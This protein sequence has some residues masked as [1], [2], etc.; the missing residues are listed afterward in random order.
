MSFFATWVIAQNIFSFLF[1]TVL[2]LTTLLPGC[3]KKNVLKLV[4]RLRI[5][6]GINLYEDGF[7]SQGSLAFHTLTLKIVKWW[8]CGTVRMDQLIFKQEKR[9]LNQALKYFL[10]VFLSFSLLNRTLS[11]LIL[12]TR[13]CTHVICSFAKKKKNDV[14]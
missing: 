9:Q 12:F 7:D 14:R 3:F 10:P 6:R 8:Y 2:K 4:S 11:S 13:I 1:P 5:W